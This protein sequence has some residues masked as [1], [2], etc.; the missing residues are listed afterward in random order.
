MPYI[1]IHLSFNLAYVL[2][3]LLKACFGYEA[4]GV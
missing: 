2:S 1:K 4:T 3:Y